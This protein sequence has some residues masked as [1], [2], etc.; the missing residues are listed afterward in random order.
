MTEDDARCAAGAGRPR[1]NGSRNG[2]TGAGEA[3]RTWGRPGRES[4]RPEEDRQKLTD[5]PWEHPL[6]TN[7]QASR[8]EGPTRQPEGSERPH[9]APSWAGAK[10]TTPFAG[11]C[12]RHGR[13]YTARGGRGQQCEDGE[14]RPFHGWNDEV[15]RP[16]VQGPKGLKRGEQVS[17]QTETLTV[18]TTV[19]VW[20]SSTST[21][22]GSTSRIMRKSLPAPRVVIQ[23]QTTP[24]SPMVI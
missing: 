20:A 9:D 12:G 21:G 13:E 2:H 22:A 8:G 5:A 18:Y 17:H 3:S 10:R 16:S 19:T 15:S 23:R 4:Q 24:V 7:N 1:R 11:C 6:R 14:L